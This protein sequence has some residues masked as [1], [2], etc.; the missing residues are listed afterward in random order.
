MKYRC[1]L[2]LFGLFLLPSTVL[3]SAKTMAESSLAVTS[4]HAFIDVHTGPG[5]GYPVFHVIEKDETITLLKRRTDWVKIKDHRGYTGWIAYDDLQH[6]IDG[7]GKSLDFKL[8]SLETWQD[9]RF[10]LGVAI[11]DFNGADS[12][13]LAV[14]YKFSKNL[15]AELRV[16]G[17]TGQF[18]SNLLGHLAITHQPFPEWRLSPYFILGAGTINTNPSATLADAEDRSD[19]A[20]LAGIGMSYY[21]MRQFVVKAEYNN[22]YILTSREENEE[23]NEWKLGFSVFF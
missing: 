19:A 8:A 18:S 1:F 14:G 13:S 3:V 5:R 20:M 22:H 12:L 7:T 23:I 6:F 9:R 21:L 11:G 16:Q 15:T 10:E 17:A 4:T 2:F